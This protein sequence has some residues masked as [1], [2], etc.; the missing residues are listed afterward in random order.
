MK[1]KLGQ[2]AGRA[3]CLVTTE[4]EK[5]ENCCNSFKIRNSNKNPFV[6][7]VFISFKT[8][9]P[10]SQN[11]LDSGLRKPQSLLNLVVK[12]TDLGYT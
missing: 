4:R 3:P 7:T 6:F 9:K 11:F 5:R 1:Q 8:L 12:D 2:E 10:E